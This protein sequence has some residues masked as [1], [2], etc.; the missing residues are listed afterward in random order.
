MFHKVLKTEGGK[1]KWFDYKGYKIQGKW[2]LSIVMKLD[3]LNI[4]WHKPKVNSEVWSYKIEG[5]QKSYTPDLYL[6]EYDLYLEIKG[7][8]WGND[9]QKMDAVIS[10][11]PN[12]K[13][14]IIEKNQYMKIMQG[15]L[16]W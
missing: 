1:C 6:E 4:K 16:V 9:K 10:Q 8:W 14:M 11:N 2:E 13:L 15:E 12:K 3:E 7:Y 5:K